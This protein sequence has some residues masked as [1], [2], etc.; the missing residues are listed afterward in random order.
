MAVLEATKRDQLGTRKTRALRAQGKI[1]GVIYGHGKSSVPVTL[2]NHALT[3]AVAHGGRLLELNLDG[4]KENVLLKDL[5]YDTFGQQIIHVDMTRVGLHERVEVTVALVLHGTPAGLI[6]GGVLQQAVSTVRIECLVTDI[7]DVIDVRVGRMQ[8]GDTLHAGDLELPS[9][10][11]L[12]DEPETVICSVIVIAEEIEE[13]APPEEGAEA[14]E[15]E[16]IGEKAEEQGPAE[17][18][19]PE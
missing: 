10:A 9:G 7:P 17:Q 6:E 1:P 16:V 5:Q 15:P 8:V 4:E 18:Q 2:D 3:A 19:T 12:L 13:A 14:A 11:T